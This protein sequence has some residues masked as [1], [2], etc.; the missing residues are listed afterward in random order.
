MSTRGIFA[1]D[2]EGTA[3]VMMEVEA[4]REWERLSDFHSPTGPVAGKRFEEGGAG[5]AGGGTVGTAA[6]AAAAADD[7]Y[8]YYY[9]L[10]FPS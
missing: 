1:A 10:L 6:A 7:N 8:D 4:V 9:F 2:W 5:V 3:A